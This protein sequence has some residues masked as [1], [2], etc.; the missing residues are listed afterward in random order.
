MSAR[1]RLELFLFPWELD[2]MS[3]YSRSFPSGTTPGKVW[4]REVF[5]EVA[6]GVNEDGHTLVR[7][8]HDGWIVGMYL[9]PIGDRVPIIWFDVVLRSGPMPRIYRAPDWDNYAHWQKLRAEER[10]KEART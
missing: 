10:K 6:V 1:P 3:E 7:K 8:V 4:R 5:R 2:A 9:E